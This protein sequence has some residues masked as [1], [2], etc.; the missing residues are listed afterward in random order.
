MQTIGIY[1]GRCNPLHLGHEAV[2]DR[3]IEEHGGRCLLIIGSSDAILSDRNP[4]SYTERE[5]FVRMLYP[6]LRIVPLPDY[7]TDA[8]RLRRLDELIQSHFPEASN[9]QIVFR[10]GAEEEVSR[11]VDDGRQIRIVDRRSGETPIVSATQV[12]E[13]LARGESLSGLVND[14]LIPVLRERYDLKRL[15]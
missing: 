7:P 8:E 5:Q 3:M 4:F 1:I 12:R 13:A 11:L 6:N 15:S 9:D 14:A 2:I 10:A